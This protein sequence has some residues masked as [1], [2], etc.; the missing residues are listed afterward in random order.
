MELNEARS[1]ASV[2][3]G[4]PEP[5]ARR[6]LGTISTTSYFGEDAIHEVS[7]ARSAWSSGNRRAVP[8]TTTLR[9]KPPVTSSTSKANCVPISTKRLVPSAV[10]QQRL[11]D[12]VADRRDVHFVDDP[13]RRPGTAQRCPASP[14]T[15]R[16][17]AR[18]NPRCSWLPP[19]SERAT[20][21]EP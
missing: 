19:R 6:R 15:R 1:P 16:C 2:W 3:G 9:A 10:E 5:P 20:C 11:V 8:L 14:S 18:R 21:T 12:A 13:E 7:S 17:P 4:E